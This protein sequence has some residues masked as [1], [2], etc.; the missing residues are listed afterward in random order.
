[1]IKKL[2]HHKFMRECL[3]EYINK[4]VEVELKE[5][6]QNIFQVRLRGNNNTSNPF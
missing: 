3:K 6:K 2:P 4:K 1:M 5:K